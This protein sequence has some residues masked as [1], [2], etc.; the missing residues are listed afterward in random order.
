MAQESV[1]KIID[2]ARDTL[3]GKL[4]NPQD[5]IDAIT[6]TLMYKFMSDVDYESVEVGGKP[7]Y[8]IG[9]YAKYDW[10]ALMNADGQEQ[11]TLYRDAIEKMSKNP[12]LPPLFREIFN[13]AML[14]F[15]DPR[16]LRLFLKEMDKFRHGENDDLGDA[17]EYLLSVMSSQGGLGQFRTPRHIIEFI[18]AAVDPDKNDRI[19]DPACGTAGFLIEAYK[20]ILTKHDGKPNTEARLTAVELDKLHKNFRGF[21][22][23]PTMIRTARVN[24]YL[25]GFK[26]PDIIENDTL[27]SEE[28]W[29]D[30]YNVIF[31]NPPFMT[32]K[33]G[34]QPHKKFSVSANRA[35]V[36]FVDYIAGHL[37][38]NG[39]AGFIVPEGIIFQSGKAYQQLR[40]NLVENSL[41]AVIS[42][43]AG[44]FQPYSGVKTSV[45][46]LSPELAK[47]RDS[48]LFIKIKNDGYS[49]GTQ[50]RKI[51]KNDLPE[52]QEIISLFQKSG[53]IPEGDTNIS[54]QLVQ[55]SE[56]AKSGN[57]NLSGDIYG[58]KE[59]IKSKFQLVRIEEVCDFIGGG[60]P[61]RAEKSY[62]GGDIKWLTAKYFSDNHKITGWETISAKGLKESSSNI[63]PANSTILISRVSVGKY[64]FAHEP[65]ALNQD[66]T[67]I[68][69]KDEKK[70]LPE[71]LFAI[72][73][74]LA[75]QIEKSAT[76][77]S[78]RG[79]SRK[80]IAGLKIPLPPLEIQKE[81]IEKIANKQKAIDHARE[82]IAVLERE[83]EYFDPRPRALR[84]G[85]PMKRLVDITDRITKGTTPTTI[86]YKY[87][88]GGINFVKV[89]SID[90]SQNFITSK[91]AHIDGKAHEALK[92]SQLQDGD[93]LFSIAGALGRVAVV[94]ESILPANTNQALSIIR[95]KNDS[96]I[97]SHY[98]ALVLGSKIIT[99]KIGGLQVGVAQQNLSLAQVSNFEIPIPPLPEQ[100]K[101]IAQFTEEQKIIAANRSLI[102]LMTGKIQNTLEEV[103]HG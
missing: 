39:K 29:H 86:G 66:L 94:D 44:V 1:R 36:L 16:T 25:H 63:A 32:P 46:L 26:T 96:Q 49:L 85:W 12:N 2:T 38:P 33:G 13:G 5:Q 23:D 7:S 91:F 64:A 6:Y 41:Y 34:I 57:Y 51:T 89:E 31:A 43:P 102:D 48:I 20:H 70:L 19:I 88:D 99:D 76:G 62:W 53:K 78:I 77:V 30:R 95:L 59:T 8:F 82:I 9:D 15:N 92:R 40:H 101:L 75:K 81:I 14:K 10:H 61:S 72:A 65:Y 21:D 68:V 42:L 17:Y 73:K 83:R 55:R 98:V 35:E 11:V 60:T 79:V 58:K 45:L 93:I 56:I 84:E 22:I 100:K 69:V 87:T 54:A 27:T 47:N 24:M 28:Y 103:W 50:R 74:E 4:P 52:A 80:F 18:V 71:F 3:V 97:G 37:K 67:A 90:E